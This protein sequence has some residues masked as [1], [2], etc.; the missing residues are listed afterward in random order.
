[1]R[2]LGGDALQPVCQAGGRG[3]CGVWPGS[4][5]GDL[6]EDLGG[7]GVGACGARVRGVGIARGGGGIGAAAKEVC[8]S[9][10]LASIPVDT[11]DERVPRRARGHGRLQNTERPCISQKADVTLDYMGKFA[12][13]GALGFRSM[14]CACGVRKYPLPRN[15][16]SAIGSAPWPRP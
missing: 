2:L 6:G 14:Y 1:M 16:R 12:Q 11:V 8:G 3:W 7:G 9:S 10:R 15:G 5:G 4:F 13:T